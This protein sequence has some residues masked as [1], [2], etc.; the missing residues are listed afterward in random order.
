[1]LRSTIAILLAV[2]CFAGTAE[3]QT[4]ATNRELRQALTA[5]GRFG[6]PG[7]TTSTLPTC[8]SGNTRAL[9]YDTT[10][11]TLVVCNGTAWGFYVGSPDFSGGTI[12]CGAAGTACVV[13]VPYTGTNAALTFE[14]SQAAGAADITKPAY[15]FDVAANLGSPDYILNFR[16]NNTTSLMSLT[17]S[18]VLVTASHVTS[19]ADLIAAAGEDV[20]W[21]G[22]SNLASGS[23]GV[24]TATNAAKTDF[25]TLNLGPATPADIGLT[26]L[27]FTNTGTAGAVI[28]VSTAATGGTDIGLR[29]VIAGDLTSTDTVF[30][31]QDA[32]G[33]D[34]LT[35]D[36]SGNLGM[37]GYVR[38]ASASAIFW[39]SRTEL[40]APADGSI[41]IA[42]TAN[43]NDTIY[44]NNTAK[45]LTAGA[46]TDVVS[47]GV[48]SGSA[49]GGEFE[50]VV[51]AAD[52]TN[53]QSRTMRVLWSAV[54]EGGTET[55]LLGTV[56]ELDNSPTGTLTA[57][58]TFV[59]GG[60]NLC[61]LQINAVSSL[62]ET[63]LNAKWQATKNHG[64]G[65]FTLL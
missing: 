61:K 1:M 51:Y 49:T 25:D 46:A 50:I 36:G 48:T 55:C 20:R 33:T 32:G 11:G 29:V 23:D 41:R 45:T 14:S 10:L 34:R 22:R 37:S 64:T 17:G 2:L 19:G 4:S 53:H 12:T 3:A 59:D 30:A 8:N 58:L 16:D 26:T 44:I 40:Y 9:A 15:L 21:S 13:N 27:Q 47:V 63:T 31:V 39:N 35:V 56:E 7:W 43:N 24:I 62:T 57:T 6:V 28:G 60:T 52:A 18:G 54:N 38:A 42:N 65:I 5:N